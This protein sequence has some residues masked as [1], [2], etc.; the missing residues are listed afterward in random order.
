MTHSSVTGILISYY[1]F[2]GWYKGSAEMH[3][4]QSG[5]I[6]TKTKNKILA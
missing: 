2:M 6:S 5:I 3:E 1:E 4:N